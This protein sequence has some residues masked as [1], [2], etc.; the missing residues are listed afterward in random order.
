VLLVDDD[1]MVRDVTLNMLL[2]LGHDAVAASS[3]LEAL[4]MLG[5]QRKFDLVITDHAMPG[6]TGSELARAIRLRWQGMRVLLISGYAMLPS[7]EDA[8][9]PRLSKPYRRKELSASIFEVME[10]GGRVEGLALSKADRTR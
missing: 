10:G 4:D 2:D 3:A 6:M 7:G 8:D 1:P 9:L 5:E